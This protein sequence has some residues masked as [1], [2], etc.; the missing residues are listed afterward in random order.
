MVFHDSGAE[1]CGNTLRLLKTGKQFLI[2]TG[3][4]GRGNCL[5][6]VRATFF[7]FKELA[8]SHCSLVS[9]CLLGIF[10]LLFLSAIICFAEDSNTTRY[11]TFYS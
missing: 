2:L 3:R 8:P 7:G 1:Q 6:V 4:N 11:E 10:I 9:E 5:A